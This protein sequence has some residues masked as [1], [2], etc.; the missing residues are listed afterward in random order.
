MEFK[1]PDRH[2][3]YPVTFKI[4]IKMNSKNKSKTRN[5]E[6]ESDSVLNKQQKFC[7]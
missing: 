6:H 2:I 7:L 5:T 4:Q 3:P 1:I